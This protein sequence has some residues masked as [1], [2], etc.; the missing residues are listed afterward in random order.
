[1]A[2]AFDLQDPWNGNSGACDG[3]PLAAFDC[4]TPWYMGPSIHPRLK[5]PVGQRLALGALHVGYA[6]GKGAHGG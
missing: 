4:H 1:M 5:K 2:H 6:K 3:Q